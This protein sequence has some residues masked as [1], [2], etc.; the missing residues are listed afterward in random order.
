MAK[1]MIAQGQKPCITVITTANPTEQEKYAASELRH[2]LS[3]M[4]SASIPLVADE[5]ADGPVIAVGAA[6]ARLGVVGAPELS[7]DGFTIKT[8]GDIVSYIESHT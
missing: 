6:A 5:N 1:Q 2:Y 4:T 7:Y 8:V 3:L